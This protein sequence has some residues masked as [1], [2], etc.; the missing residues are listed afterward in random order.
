[1]LFGWLLFA[2]A[3]E[4]KDGAGKNGAPPGFQLWILPVL[5]LLFY[6]LVLAPGRRQRQEQANLLKGL[7]KND[8]VV[9]HSGIIGVVLNIK[10]GS[11]EITIKS[12]ETKLR[13]VKSAV[14]R[15][16]PSK[17]TKEVTEQK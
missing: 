5:L 17:E 4:A 11:E 2:G 1:M 8:E 3:E 14:A 9:T 12:D 16:I 13:I 10:E 7:K 6:F 15:I